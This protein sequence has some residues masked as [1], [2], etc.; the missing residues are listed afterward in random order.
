MTDA[1]NLILRD[2]YGRFADY[3]YF[4]GCSTG[5]HP[6]LSQAQRYPGDYDG[7]VAGDPGNDRI[8]LNVG[9]LWSWLAL[10][11]SAAAQLPASKVP[12]IH[13][14]VMAACDSV[15]RRTA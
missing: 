2:Y 8:R 4:I 6:A 15:D 5:G 10:N 14:A 9:F 13:R 3:A 1:A 12:M 7:I 11:Q